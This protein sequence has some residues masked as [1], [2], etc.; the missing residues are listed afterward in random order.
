MQ[1]AT[2]S[3]KSRLRSLKCLPSSL[4]DLKLPSRRYTLPKFPLLPGSLLDSLPPR[5]TPRRSLLTPRKSLPTLRKR[6]EC[7]SRPSFVGHLF[8]T[9]LF[10][11]RN[12]RRLYHLILRRHLQYESEKSLR[13]ARN[14]STCDFPFF[15]GKSP[16]E[17][18]VDLDRCLHGVGHASTPI[19]LPESHESRNLSC[20]K[21]RVHRL[22]FEHVNSPKLHRS[23]RL[24]ANT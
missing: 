9:S 15:S 5:P 21:A 17:I 1:T 12:E 4:L 14:S 24:C 11:P 20:M 18:N 23:V 13:D 2:R 8:L 7:D 10:R 16:R 3:L 22:N 6:L 19:L